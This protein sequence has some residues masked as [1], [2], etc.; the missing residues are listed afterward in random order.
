[1]FTLFAPAANVYPVCPCGKCLHCFPLQQMFT[2]FV[3]TANVY[4][5]FPCSKGLPCL[6]LQQM[7]TL[8][9]PAANVYP[10]CSAANAYPVCPCG[11]CELGAEEEIGE[12]E[13]QSVGHGGLALALSPPSH[14]THLP[15]TQANS[16]LRSETGYDLKL[17]KKFYIR[18]QKME[19]I[20]ETLNRGGSVFD[21]LT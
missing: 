13:K 9:S 15:S 19:K 17:D 20:F 2:L 11:H 21:S 10:V 8:F 1:M 6:S 12:G 18:P 7:F 16:A 14:P 4:P 3:P 5:V